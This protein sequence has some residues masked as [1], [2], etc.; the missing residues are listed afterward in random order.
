M[1]LRVCRYFVEHIPGFDPSWHV[2]EQEKKKEQGA[3]RRLNLLSNI[4]AVLL[5]SGVTIL[6]MWLW[7]LWAK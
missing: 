3:I 6:A 5:G 1:T 2:T 4:L 7:Q